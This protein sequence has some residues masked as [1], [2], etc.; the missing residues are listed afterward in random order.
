M[1][2]RPRFSA[3]WPHFKNAASE[4]F[5]RSDSVKQCDFVAVFNKEEILQ[6]LMRKCGTVSYEDTSMASLGTHDRGVCD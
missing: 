5:F 4:P 1:G 2:L 3:L 6:G